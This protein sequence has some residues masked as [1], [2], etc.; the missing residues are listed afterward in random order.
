VPNRQNPI[1]EASR[2]ATWVLFETGRELRVARY[3]EGM[4]QRQ[5]GDAAHR[6][7]SRISRIEAGK[8]GGVSMA[9]LMRVAAAVGLRLYVATYPGGRRPLDTP[10]L[11]ML[12]ALNARIHPTWRR[13]LEKVMPKPGDLRAVDEL[14]SMPTFTCAIEAISRFADVQAQVRS[15]R[16]KQRDLAATRLIHLIKASHANRRMLHEAGEIVRENFPIGTRQALRLLGAGKDPGGDCLIL[17]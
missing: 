14:I 16:A 2:R 11:E 3:R 10:Q 9:E 1:H 7:A 13:E 4:T 5:V 8:V 12:R 15:A 17:I 6:S